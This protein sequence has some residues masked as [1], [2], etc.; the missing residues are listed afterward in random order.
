MDG[1]AI[2]RRVETETTG[3]CPEIGEQHELCMYLS[4]AVS[5]H[6]TMEK[7]LFVFETGGD[8]RKG[9]EEHLRFAKNHVVY[10]R[11]CL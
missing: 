4:V 3:E 1:P 11:E 2:C 7:E 10:S 6:L 8:L 9:K 5:L